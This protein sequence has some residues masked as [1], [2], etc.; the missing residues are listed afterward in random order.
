MKSLNLEQKMRIKMKIEPIQLNVN[1]GHVTTFV[2][3]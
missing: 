1:N 3:L 2:G